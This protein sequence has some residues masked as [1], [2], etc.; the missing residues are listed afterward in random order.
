M[1]LSPVC[2]LRPKFTSPFPPDTN[3]H[4]AQTRQL[5]WEHLEDGEPSVD[6]A[7]YP[8]ESPGEGETA[9]AGD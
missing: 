4:R 9:L 8:K 5:S 2:S 1:A 3:Q 7:G 6:G